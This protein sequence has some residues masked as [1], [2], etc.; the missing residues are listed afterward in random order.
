[1]VLQVQAEQAE[2]AAVDKPSI[3]WSTTLIKGRLMAISIA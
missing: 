1:M 2:Q 3:D